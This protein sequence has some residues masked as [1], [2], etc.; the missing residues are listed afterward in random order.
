[1]ESVFKKYLYIH[2]TNRGLCHTSFLIPES[3]PSG[4]TS[5]LEAPNGTLQVQPEASDA[6]PRALKDQPGAGAMETQL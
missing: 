5:S 1:M 3:D 4:S 2:S 6:Y